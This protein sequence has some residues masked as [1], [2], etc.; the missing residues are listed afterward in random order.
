MKIKNKINWISES[1]CCAAVAIYK[2]LYPVRVYC[3]SSEREHKRQIIVG[4]LRGM[5][6]GSRLFS[7]TKEV[8]S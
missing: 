1:Q 5:L 3:E 8:Q 4:L 7:L 6:A 2:K